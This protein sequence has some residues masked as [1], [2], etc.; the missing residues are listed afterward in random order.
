MVV[1][2]DGVCNMCNGFVRFLIK[3][4]KKNTLQFASLQSGYGKALLAHYKL[5]TST[6]ETVIL[7]TNKQILTESAA[8]I[9]IVSS[10]N[11]IWKA[12][13]IF[14][15]IPGFIRNPLYRLIARNRYTLFGKRD[16]CPIPTEAE[17]SRFLDDSPFS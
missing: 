6:P 7:Y 8:V 17:K 3:R 13:L 4:D 15:I 16:A 5:P 14:K 10:L 1:L 12:V 2:F 11:G 9:K